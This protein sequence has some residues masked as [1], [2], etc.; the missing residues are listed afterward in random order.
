MNINTSAPSSRATFLAPAFA[1]CGALA[2]FA[3]CASEESHVVSAPPPVPVT[4]VTTTQTTQT[5]PMVMQTPTYV[6]TSPQGTTA[7][8]TTTT[9]NPNTAVNTIIVTSAPPALQQEVVLARPSG[10]Y[11]WVL[12]YWT[13]QESRYQW[14]AGHWELP[15]YKGSSWIPPHTEQDGNAY[16]FYEGHWN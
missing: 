1:L 16:R 2:M 8:T 13:W 7:Y 6:T 14:M 4:Q 5:V 10:D 15:P 3:G 9:S 12:G 11:V